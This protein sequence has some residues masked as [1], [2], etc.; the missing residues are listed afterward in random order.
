MGDTAGAV[1]LDLSLIRAGQVVADIVYHPLET[2]LLRE[3]ST[4]GAT[5][6]DGLGMLVH[7][8]CRQQIAWTG[9]ESD[10]AVL[11]AAALAELARR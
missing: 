8:A 3:A 1:P 7:Q 6:V 2:T 11:R 4:R 10:P 9:V 5:T